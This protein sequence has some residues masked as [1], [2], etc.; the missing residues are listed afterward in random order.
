MR[1]INQ[2]PVFHRILD[3]LYESGRTDKELLKY[4][5]LANGSMTQ[6]KYRRVKSYMKYINKIATMTA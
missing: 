4:L 6:W 1:E 3:K 5:D 2:D